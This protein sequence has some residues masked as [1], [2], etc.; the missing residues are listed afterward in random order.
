MHLTKGYFVVGK[1]GK[2]TY[3]GGKVSPSQLRYVGVEDDLIKAYDRAKSSLD[4]YT[5]SLNYKGET[6][7]EKE[8]REAKFK[9]LDAIEKRLEELSK[10]K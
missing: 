9:A 8:L 4:V 1:N 2:E 5:G 10:N 3:V 7:K 6:E